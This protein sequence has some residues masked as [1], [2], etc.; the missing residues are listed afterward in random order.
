V[1]VE[2]STSGI[3]KLQQNGPVVMTERVASFK[4]PNKSFE[5]PVMDLRGQGRKIKACATIST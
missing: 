3:I 5:L 4:L 1:P 2:A